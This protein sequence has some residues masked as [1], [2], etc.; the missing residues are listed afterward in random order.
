MALLYRSNSPPAFSATNGTNV[1]CVVSRS[2]S[3][4]NVVLVFVGQKPS[5]ANGGTVTTP[6]GF[7]L[8]DS[9]TGAGGY[10]TTLGADTGN[11]NIFVYRRVIDGTEGWLHSDTMDVTVA[12]NSVCSATMVRVASGSGEY[13]FAAT[14]GSDTAGGNVSVT[15]GADPGVAA[16]D[17]VFAFFVCASDAANFS[18]PGLSQ[19]GVTF[20]AVTEIVETPSANGNDIGGVLCRATVTAGTSS[21]APVFAATTGGTTTNARGPAV[22][23]RVRELNPVAITNPGI[24]ADGLTEYEYL[25]LPVPTLGGGSLTIYGKVW[26]PTAHPTNSPGRMFAT[27][28]DELRLVWD[29]PYLAWLLWSNEANGASKILYER[30]GEVFIAAVF[31]ANTVT[32]YWRRADQF[33]LGKHTRDLTANPLSGTSTYFELG[34]A[35][36]EYQYWGCYVGALTEAQLLAQSAATTQLVPGRSWWPLTNGSLTD[37]VGGY[38]ATVSGFQSGS[39]ELS[40]GI[41]TPNADYSTHFGDRVSDTAIEGSVRCDVAIP[42]T[43]STNWSLGGYFRLPDAEINAYNVAITTAD[44]STSVLIFVTQLVDTTPARFDTNLMSSLNGDSN[45]YYVDC[46]SRAGAT[47]WMYRHWTFT[48]SGGNTTVRTYGAT[49]E[50][51]TLTLL[52]TASFQIPEVFSGDYYVR[53]NVGNSATVGYSMRDLRVHLTAL[54]LEQIA[55]LAATHSPDTTAWA[56][57]GL[58]DGSLADLSGNTGRDLFVFRDDAFRGLA[59]PTLSA[60]GTTFTCAGLGFGGG[61]AATSSSI[62]AALA[63]MAT[64]RSSAAAAKAQTIDVVGTLVSESAGSGRAS[65]GLLLAGAVASSNAAPARPSVAS[66]VAGVARSSSGAPAAFAASVGVVGLTQSRGFVLPAYQSS[67]VV[68]GTAANAAHLLGAASLASSVSGLAESRSAASGRVQSGSEFTG[69]GVASTVSVLVGGAAITVQGAGVAAG[70]A[71]V[72]GVTSGSVAARGAA[73]TASSAMGA[74]GAGSLFTG[75]GASYGAAALVGDA[76]S[77]ALTQG[78]A[79]SVGGA[80]GN[81]SSVAAAGGM[82]ASASSSRAASASGAETIGLTVGLSTARGAYASGSLFSGLGATYGASVL[83][84]RA[85]SVVLVQGR[86][87]S[88]ASAAGGAATAATAAGIAVTAAAARAS[89]AASVE[90]GGLTVGVS[91][92]R[93]AATSGTL[94]DGLGLVSSGS[95]AVG[96]ASSTKASTGLA[97]SDDV[98]TG[99][100]SVEVLA[101]GFAGGGAYLAGAASLA[102]EALGLSVGRSFLGARTAPIII[103]IPASIAAQFSRLFAVQATIERLFVIHAKR[104]S[105]ADFVYVGGTIDVS[106]AARELQAG[107]RVLYD[108]TRLVVSI[109][110][111]DG[112]T[113]AMTYAGPQDTDVRILRESVGRFRLIYPAGD[114]V[115]EALVDARVTEQVG[116]IPYSVD[117]FEP[118]HIEVR[119]RPVGLVDAPAPVP[120]APA[121]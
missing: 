89:S 81:S 35:G 61:F 111:P 84:G 41:G 76:S 48:V 102:F 113:D 116:E 80:A 96:A 64:S 39:K 15:F 58:A 17:H 8:I 49:G 9:I 99:G 10:G 57:W 83:A 115:G 98:A 5:S 74:Y 106:F 108:P 69:A 92:A 91:I 78:R 16:N 63:A 101:G 28:N 47:V 87:P 2:L 72:P 12:T 93:G 54:S 100:Q 6:D 112:S 13:S 31:S 70:Q 26:I 121:P 104:T 14:T 27:S 32:F 53:L 19:T 11:T 24:A 51:G 75:Q 60:G 30:G 77:G 97:D 62:V 109:R 82:A 79:P 105:M 22:F 21:A 88:A 40:T 85:S 1:A 50:G 43:A 66:A 25:R 114:T 67:A 118:L 7:T 90:A 18:S 29:N 56:H 46:G 65:S 36:L 86:G 42:L 94:F 20:S 23:V 45:A 117:L 120:E 34:E 95:A 59:G 33:T 103:H 44:G 73:G 107:E 4:G 68:A 38:N 55:A 71:W 37:T 3:I 110:L 52:G 119:A